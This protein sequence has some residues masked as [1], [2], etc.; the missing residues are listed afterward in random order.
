MSRPVKWARQDALRW[1]I[2]VSHRSRCE[3][4]PLIRSRALTARRLGD[5]RSTHTAFGCGW[6]GAVSHLQPVVVDADRLELALH[7][8]HD[9]PDVL[10]HRGG[11]LR[12]RR[13]HGLL[14][15]PLPSQGRQAGGV[16]AR[17]QKARVVAHDRDGGRRRGHVGAG[18]GGLASVRHGA[19]GRHRSRSHGPAVALELPP[20]GQGRPAGHIRRPQRQ[21]RQPAGLESQ[22]SATDRTTS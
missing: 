2:E 3:L 4:R 7:R 22:R 21:S 11:F 13:L 20:S 17:K 18:P 14:R 19:G 9:L 1:P 8:R 15:L 6:L 16:R 5:D 10:D 12:G